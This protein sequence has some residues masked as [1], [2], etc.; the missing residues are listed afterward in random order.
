MLYDNSIRAKSVV[1]WTLEQTK[2][3]RLDLTSAHL[4][5]LHRAM[6]SP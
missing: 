5:H 6:K 2:T 1:S 3:G 4:G